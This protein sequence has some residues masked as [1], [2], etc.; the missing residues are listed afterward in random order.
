VLVV[1]SDK[2]GWNSVQA[3][4][5]VDILPLPIT[6]SALV[7][8]VER[9]LIR[10]P[11]QDHGYDDELSADDGIEPVLE[12]PPPP[13]PAAAKPVVQ[14]VG[15][16]PSAG[17]VR[18]EPLPE[19]PVTRARMRSP[20]PAPAPAAAPAETAKPAPQRPPVREPALAQRP[21]IASR[22]SATLV[23]EL[24][25]EANTLP[26]LRTIADRVAEQARATAGADAAVVLLPDDIVWEVC[27]GAGVRPVERRFVVE[28]DGWL[29]ETV[30]AGGRGIII[31]DSDIARQRLGGAPLAHHRQFMAVPIPGPDGLLLVAR[32][33]PT[34]DEGSLQAIVSAAGAAA[35][36]LQ[37]AL[38]VRTLARALERYID[39]ED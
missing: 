22:Q 26:D 8:A 24:L 3:A 9:M 37:E 7:D 33:D 6:R 17:H 18:V 5:D 16:T 4:D 38:D 21:R 34:F 10:V 35:T 11:A 32:T 28:G 30:V 14:E 25:A 2:P 31:E 12:T 27:G 19:P 29:I 36:E 23:R 13:P 20:E 39:R 1:S 15:P